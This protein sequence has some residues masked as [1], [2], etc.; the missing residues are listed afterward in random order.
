M[1]E[2]DAF[3]LAQQLLARMGR[4]AEH[5]GV[6]SSSANQMYPY[7]NKGTRS[8]PLALDLKLVR[9]L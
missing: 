9:S 4:S 6:P 5:A 8:S 1:S 2:N 3:Y 7:D